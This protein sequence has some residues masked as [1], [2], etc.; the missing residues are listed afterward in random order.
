MELNWINFNNDRADRFLTQTSPRL[1]NLLGK[2]LWNWKAKFTSFTWT[3]HRE[4]VLFHLQQDVDSDESVM[5]ILIWFIE[6][7]TIN[8]L[9]IQTQVRWKRILEV[10][11]IYFYQKRSSSVL[12]AYIIYLPV[13]LSTIYSPSLDEVKHTYT[14]QVH[15]ILPCR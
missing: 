15:P 4:A 2:V 6:N 12:R 5:V 9:K 13:S 11:E 1:Q 14:L 3:L 7:L 10:R 8:L